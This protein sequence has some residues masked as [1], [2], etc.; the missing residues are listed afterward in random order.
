MSGWATECFCTAREAAGALEAEAPS[1]MASSAAC[2]C[3]SQ[4]RSHRSK[5]GQTVQE[6]RTPTMGDTWHTS[7]RT[8]ACTARTRGRWGAVT[9]A[10][11]L[12]AEA[13][14]EDA[15]LSDAC[16]ALKASRFVSLMGGVDGRH[17]SRY[18][19]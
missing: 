16:N 1:C 2:R 14:E 6:Y 5:S 7:H 15:E 18:S 4:H 17:S 9:A 3:A 13:E 19:T 12:E 11:E 8:P 10:A